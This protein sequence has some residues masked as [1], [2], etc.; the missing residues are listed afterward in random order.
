[1]GLAT[2]Y[3]SWRLVVAETGVPEGYCVECVCVEYSTD[4]KGSP[5]S[6]SRHSAR[7]HHSLL[8]SQ[9]FPF[10]SP[11]GSVCCFLPHLF[12]SEE[13]NSGVELWEKQIPFP[14]SR[15]AVISLRAT[16]KSI[17]WA[18]RVLNLVTRYS[19]VQ[20]PFP[21]IMQKRTGRLTNPAAKIFVFIFT[22]INS[23]K[24]FKVE[25]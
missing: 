15:N 9:Y 17:R 25:T 20:S 5:P 2:R 19:L 7:P 21:W 12:L 4:E 18:H 23:R 3:N 11:S 14:S 16:P 6:S 22:S 1:M 24:Y 8:L 13:E 10:W